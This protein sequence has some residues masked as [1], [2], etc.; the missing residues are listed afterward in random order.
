M[1]VGRVYPWLRDLWA[2]E[3]TWWP[4]WAPRKFYLFFGQPQLNPLWSFIDV[5]YQVT[6]EGIVSADR[7]SVRYPLF[8]EVGVW[9]GD[10]YLFNQFSGLPNPTRFNLIITRAGIPNVSVR[11]QIS[12]YSGPLTIAQ[13]DESDNIPP[14]YDGSPPSG[15]VRCAVW[16]EV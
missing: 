1:H 5:D 3:T 4:H 14:W 7:K 10:L 15:G 6:G 2:V 13:W 8:G 11:S 16:S 9:N 12:T